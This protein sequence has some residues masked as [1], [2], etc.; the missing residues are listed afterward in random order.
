MDPSNHTIQALFKQLGLS[1]ND[2][3]IDN[4]IHNNY[5]PLE[6]PLE[7]AAIWS[8]GQAQFI[9]ESIALEADWAEAVDHLDALLRHWHPA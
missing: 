5:L 1:S 8:A 7:N 6:I 3:A 2:I 9:H 4:F